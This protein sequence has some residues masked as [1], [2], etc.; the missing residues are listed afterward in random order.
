[1]TSIAPE[2]SLKRIPFRA[3]SFSRISAA[4]VITVR[5]S[6]FSFL[7]SFSFQASSESSGISSFSKSRTAVPCRSLSTVW[8]V[9]GSS[10]ANAAIAL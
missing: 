2:S 7:R 1:M 4:L 9:S 6:P 10:E 8:I 5:M 3:G